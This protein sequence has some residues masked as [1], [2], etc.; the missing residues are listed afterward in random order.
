MQGDE[1]EVVEGQGDDEMMDVEVAGGQNSKS[2]D[3]ADEMKIREG[4]NEMKLYRCQ[5]VAN[6]CMQ[7]TSSLATYLQ[8]PQCWKKHLKT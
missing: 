5:A 1:M 8:P 6:H 4:C 2:D 3:F 7:M